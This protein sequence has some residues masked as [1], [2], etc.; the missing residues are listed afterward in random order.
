[1][2]FAGKDRDSAAIARIAPVY[3]YGR[4]PLECLGLYG[5]DQTIGK[6]RRL[7]PCHPLVLARPV[8]P[9]SRRHSS[10]VLG[11]EAEAEIQRRT[12]SRGEKSPI[13]LRNL[14]CGRFSMA[15][16]HTTLIP[17]QRQR[18]SADVGVGALGGNSRLSQGRC[19]WT[20]DDRMAEPWSCWSPNI[21]NGS[22]KGKVAK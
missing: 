6:A 10:S 4:V 3:H 2:R 14:H 5:R 9:G 22:I 8:T 7:I 12:S 18:V 13:Q 15:D 19:V 21:K 11:V 17:E 20:M 1:M 16:P